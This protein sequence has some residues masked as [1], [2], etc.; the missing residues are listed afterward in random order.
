MY[1]LVN[2]K[3]LNNNDLNYIS[4]G[5]YEL[6]KSKFY[7]Y[8]FNVDNLNDITTHIN[9][10]KSNNKKARHILYAY[11]FYENNIKYSKFNNDGE[12]NGTGINSIITMLEKEN[13]TN[14]LVVLVRY[15]GGTKLRS[16]PII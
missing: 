3:K 4:E 13:V 5:Y 14:Y 11:E 2:K 16:R 8:I 6:K 15:F 10:I 7:S 1:K 12:P 9:N